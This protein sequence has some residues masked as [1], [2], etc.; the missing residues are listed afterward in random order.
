MDKFLERYNQSLLKKRDNFNSII[1]INKVEIVVKILSTNKTSSPDDF[2][3]K[4]YQTFKL[5][6][7]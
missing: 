1:C 2:T 4:F 3:G 5:E 7:I 6:I